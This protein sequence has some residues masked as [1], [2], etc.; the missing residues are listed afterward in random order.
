MRPAEARALCADLVELPWDDVADRGG[1]HRSVGGAARREPQVT[2]VIGRSTGCGGSAPSGS[3]RWGGERAA[4]ASSCCAWPSAGI[5]APRVAIAGSCVAAR[6]ATWAGAS[7]DQR[8]ESTSL[9]HVVPAGTMPPISP[10]LRSPSCRWTRSCAR[11]LHALGLRTVGALAALTAED[12][13]RRWGDTGIR[14]WR[15]RAPTTCVVPCSRAFET[16]PAVEVELASPASTM[17]PVLF[18]VRAALDRLVQELL[19]HGAPAAAVAITLTL[20][21]ARGALVIGARAHG[22]ARGA[23]GAPARARRPLFERCR[24]LLDRWTLSAPVMRGARSDRRG[25]AT[26]RRAGRSAERLV[27]R[28]RVPPTRPLSGCG[29]EL[30]PDR[31]RARRAPGHAP[32]GEGRR[33]GG[34]R[35]RWSPFRAHVGDMARDL[36]GAGHPERAKRSR[37]I[38]TRCPARRTRQWIAHTSRVV[39]EPEPPPQTTA[40]H[41][42]LEPASVE[43]ECDGEVPRVVTGSGTGSRCSTADRTGAAVGRLVG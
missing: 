4:R 20:D 34:T 28:H 29:V 43:V 37:G 18:L 9:V 13:E 39:R 36:I 8:A 32:A 30:G 33:V 16:Q 7:F 11:R 17:E 27:A 31:H 25:G 10:L 14:A 22:H 38:C 41:R 24:A 40:A 3:I 1:D 6:A 26:H 12:V 15:L 23:S 19:A 21:D 35:S 2:P 5:Q 42:A